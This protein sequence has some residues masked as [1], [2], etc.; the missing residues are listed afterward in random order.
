MSTDIFSLKLGI[1]SSYLIRG[2]KGIIMIDA[3]TPN[4]LRVFKRKL[5][6]LY[7]NPRDVKMIILTH[8]HFDHAGS[9]KDIKDLTGAKIVIHE[10][11]KSYLE[12][13]GFVMPKG[14]NTWGKIT[15]QILFPFFKKIPFP[16]PK[17]DI[18][19]GDKEMSLSEFGIDGIIIHTPGHTLGSLSV[20]LNTGEAFVGCLAHGGFPFR[21]G[22]GL[23]IYAQDIEKVKESWKLIIDK[24]AR[25]IFPG[26]GNPFPVEIIKKKLLHPNV[27]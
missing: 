19:V 3:G 22:S 6:R 4:K 9:A 15:R 11:E 25:I 10:S 13:S 12:E 20:L 18:I 5:S 21:I 27:L 24:G 1:N 2:V 8:S 7:I 14:V 16:R 23:P 17:A 26:H